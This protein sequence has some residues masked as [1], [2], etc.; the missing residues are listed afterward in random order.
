MRQSLTLFLLVFIASLG[1]TQQEELVQ[2]P[3]A[4]DYE[5]LDGTWNVIIDP[6]ENGFYNHRWKPRKNGF[7]KDEKPKDK[8]HRI[9]YDF[10]SDFQ[11]NVPGDWNTQMDK[12]Y[13]YEGTVWYRKK[14]EVDE[15]AKDKIYHLYFEAVNYTTQVYLN[16]ELIGAHTGGFTPFNFDVSDRLLVGENTLILKV[17]NKRDP[18][19]IPTINT[20]WWNYGGVTRSVMLIT[21]PLT[22]I[23]DYLVQL[24]PNN[25]QYIQG[26]VQLNE[27]V[28]GT[29]RLAIGALK[30]NHTIAIQEGKG[31]F[32]VKAKPKLW[33]PE[34]PELY[35]LSIR[36]EG[37]I[38]ADKL[39][40]RTIRVKGNDMLLNGASIFLRGISI[41]EEAP[42]GNGRVSTQDERRSL[43]S[44]AKELGCNYIRLSH[45]PHAEQMVRMAEEMGFL[46]WSEIPV[47]WSVNYQNEATYTLAEQQ[48]REMISR[49]K[50]RGS[51]IMWSVANETPVSEDRNRFLQRLIGKARALD[52]TRLIV[53]AL[54]THGSENGAKVIDDPLGEFVDVIGIN[55]Y[56]GWYGG[57]PASCKEWKWENKYDKPMIMSEVGGGALQ[58]LH[59]DKDEIW[60]EEYQDEVFKNN[61]IMIDN[62]SFLRGLSPWILMDFRSPRRH[63]RRIQADFN[64][65]GLISENGIRKKAFFR[66]QEYYLNKK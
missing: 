37:Q 33:S 11:L 4:R 50:N 28:N 18:D 17:D 58:G 10:D 60:T 39:A 49:D 35:D 62:I 23:Q 19:G 63:L 38:L 36:Y 51:I 55:S 66:L 52:G 22:Y 30:L 32:R 1:F 15:L 43:L 9:E 6:M 44:W 42:M 12:L 54:D 13:Y 31:S 7:F 3:R 27:K 57:T 34:S 64:R 16:G 8:S 2:N 61:L 59:G 14:F 41:H 45:Y 26:Y 53:A 47:Y 48:L 21:S 56:C 46:V 25:T 40:F 29:A 65:K 20:D 5:L 24:D